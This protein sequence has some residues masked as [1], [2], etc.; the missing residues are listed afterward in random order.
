MGFFDFLSPE[1]NSDTNASTNSNDSRRVNTTS[2]SGLTAQDGGTLNFNSI[3]PGAFNLANTTVDKGLSL[4]SQI[5]STLGASVGQFSVG[6][7]NSVDSFT[8]LLDNQQTGI[9]AMGANNKQ[10]TMIALVMG[11]LVAIAALRR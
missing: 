6:A 2:G 1:S 7:T 10:I 4:A 11:G 5:A 8:H 9:T 3:D